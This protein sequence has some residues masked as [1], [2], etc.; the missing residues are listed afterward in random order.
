MASITYT[1]GDATEPIGPG[2]KVLVHVCNDRG[3]WGKGFVVAISKRWKTPEAAYRRWFSE[4]GADPFELG[5]VLIVKVAEELWVANL[6]GQQGMDAK[7][8]VP[9][10]RYAAIA[11]GLERVAEFA[12]LHDA[13]VHMPR[14]GCGLAGGKWEEIETIIQRTLLATDIEVTVYDYEPR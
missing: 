6:V 4:G 13:S 11:T 10:V 12:Q 7:A 8:G 3:R 1:T 14:I 5:Q 2:P 9:P